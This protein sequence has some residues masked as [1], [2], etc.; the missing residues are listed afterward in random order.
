MVSFKNLCAYLVAAASLV[1][2]VKTPT[3]AQAR[4]STP[5]PAESR[6]YFYEPAISPDR[7]EIAFVSGG[8]VWT[9][10]S[11]GGEARLLVSHPAL[12]AAQTMWESANLKVHLTGKVILTMGT[13]PQSQGHETLL[14]AVVQVSFD[15]TTGVVGG[16][17]H[18]SRGTRTDHVDKP[19]GGAG[20][21]R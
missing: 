3:R 8:D 19:S 20:R 2:G 18:V 12:K 16:G 11:E 7:K 5:Q 10:P 14:D 1:S 9:V 15:A 13:Q 21:A 17:N 6:P 4:T